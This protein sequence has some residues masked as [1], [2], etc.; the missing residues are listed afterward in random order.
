MISIYNF[1]YLLRTTALELKPNAFIE[2]GCKTLTVDD[3]IGYIISYTLTP[4]QEKKI[5]NRFGITGPIKKKLPDMNERY[6]DLIK[7]LPS[8]FNQYKTKLE[9][10]K[11]KFKGMKGGAKKYFVEEK[12][13]NYTNMDKIGYIMSGGA[14]L[15]GIDQLP[16]EIKTPANQVSDLIDSFESLIDG[17]KTRITTL[18]GTESEKDAE[19]NRLNAAIIS[20]K[21]EGERALA[22]AD[23]QHEAALK[24]L[25]EASDSKAAEA[26]AAAEASAAAAAASAQQQIDAAQAALNKQ[27][28]E[29]ASDSAKFAAIL[30]QLKTALEGKKNQLQ[31]LVEQPAATTG[32]AILKGL[33]NLSVLPK[34]H[35]GGMDAGKLRDNYHKIK[36]LISKNNGVYSKMVGGNPDMMNLGM[37][38]INN[39][40]DMRNLIA[41]SLSM[42]QQPMP[43][44][45]QQMIPALFQQY[46]NQL[47]Q[48]DPLR[49]AI[50]QQI[51]AMKFQ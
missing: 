22:E 4:E 43:M 48:N 26:A 12:F 24:A 10:F 42:T 11:D 27:K 14:P 36:S 41:Q 15:T 7:I 29:R 34:I 50:M 30:G 23:A 19:I 44:N 47:L 3:M 13:S 1:P 33:N 8:I 21:G 28:N 37:Q 2:T 17:I 18:S 49:A 40:S 45:G 6:Y 20:A 9:D 39:Y 38:G 35:S 46:S 31:D 16:E 51:P 5:R 25:Q 32:G